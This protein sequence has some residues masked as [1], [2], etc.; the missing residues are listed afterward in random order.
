MSGGSLIAHDLVIE[1]HSAAMR[2]ELFAHQDTLLAHLPPELRGSLPDA[3]NAPPNARLLDVLYRLNAIKRLGDGMIPLE[4]WLKN[5]LVLSQDR[6]EREVF[7]R[8]L[9]ALSGACDPA[10]DKRV[11]AHPGSVYPP[12]HPLSQE[13][14]AL[15]LERARCAAAGQSTAPLHGKILELKRRLRSGMAFRAHELLADGRFELLAEVGHGGFGEVWR[16]YDHADGQDVAVKLLHGHLRED[17]QIRFFRGARCMA[18]LNHA[19]V[20]RVVQS[21]GAE[22]RE[23][24]YVRYFFVMEFLSGGDFK[25][26]V[27]AHHWADPQ[28]ALRVVLQAGSGLAFAHAHDMVHRDVTPDNIL[29]DKDGV[30]RLTDFDLVRAIDTTGMTH[31]GGMGKYFFAAP[32]ALQEARLVDSRADIYSLAMTAVYAIHGS[33]PPFYFESRA[34]FISALPCA[35]PVRSVLL[36][37]GA[38]DPG[39]RHQTVAEFCDD[40]SRAIGRTA[41]LPTFSDLEA[42]LTRSEDWSTLVELYLGRHEQAPSPGESA[43]MLRRVS[44]IVEHHLDDPEEAIIALTEALR[45]DPSSAPVVEDL[46]R[47]A[48][49][50]GRWS[51]VAEAIREPFTVVG[52][53][54]KLRLGLALGRCL[55]EGPKDHAA[56]ERCYEEIVALDAGATVL[57]RLADLFAK[58]DQPQKLARVLEWALALER[59]MLLHGRWGEALDLLALRAE[60][61]LT[62]PARTA[63]RLGL[64]HVLEAELKR[65]AEAVDVYE[66]IMSL[67]ADAL[68][69][70][71]AEM[72]LCGLERCYEEIGLWS[73][74]GTTLLRRAAVEPDAA[75]RRALKGR[76]AEVF[77]GLPHGATRAVELRLELLEDSVHAGAW[78]E[79]AKV[80]GKLVEGSSARP[81]R[82]L[83]RMHLIEG[84][85][86]EA[87]GNSRGAEAAYARARMVDPGVLRPAGR[88]DPA[89]TGEGSAVLRSLAAALLQQ[90]A[91]QTDAERA[92][93]HAFAATVFDA[94]GDHEAALRASS[95][96]HQIEQRALE[97]FRRRPPWWEVMFDEDFS[98]TLERLEPAGVKRE[99]DF[100]EE[101]LGLQKR[102]MILDLACGAGKH[103]VELSSRSYYLVGY[104]LS[105]PMLAR[106]YEQAFNDVHFVRGEMRRMAFQGQFDGIYCWNTS[107]GYFDDAT[108][109]NVLSRIHRALRQRGRF[110]LDVPNRDHVCLHQPSQ[111][112]FEGDGCVCL[113]EMDVD[114]FTSRLRVKR[115]AMFEGGLSRELDYSIRLYTLHE[116]GKLLHDVGFK[117]VEVTGHPAHPG[118]FFGTESPR[119]IVLA[120]RS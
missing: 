79:A 113:D 9:A 74:L 7:E 56:A 85:A 108:N 100:I 49:C 19:H 106:A 86:L 42:Q 66:A 93:R 90:A 22:E 50:T 75:A 116:L 15:Y 44:R 104:D 84:L 41:S 3:A 37:A 77:A 83:A 40:L 91:G 30:A 21:Y 55:T 68:S 67:P 14:R 72:A 80:A 96:P 119:L 43:E 34:Q 103:A 4:G 11:R 73:E 105:L 51:E 95:V 115:T 118:V 10:P 35:E 98:R 92:R 120:E 71:D 109:F 16:A 58:T 60:L 57:R 61:A 32:E 99:C 88:Y 78:P 1:V 97:T 17:M 65:H 70:S 5:A 64:A 8:A 94:A 87:L 101:R 25:Q 112:W 20:A 13:L 23:E 52:G 6:L 38:A 27:Q 29:L 26:A 62:A 117:V 63:A 114:F 36:K 102:A 33:V 24:N 110:L 46:E 59:E 69:S 48:R 12:D 39:A 89:P 81:L 18:K 31:S 107:F 111:G 47:L 76:A 2:L 45:L 54:L 28:D 82:E 53:D